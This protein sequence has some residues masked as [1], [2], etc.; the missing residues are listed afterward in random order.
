MANYLASKAA[1]HEYVRA[2]ADELRLS[3]VRAVALLPGTI[4]TDA[5]RAAMPTADRSAWLA[6]PTVV[7]ALLRLALGV[8]PQESGP[9]YPITALR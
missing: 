4:D 9:L 3:P 7:E 8:L 2:L 5:N 1:L 6:V